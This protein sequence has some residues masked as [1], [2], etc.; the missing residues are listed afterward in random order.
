MNNKQC[1]NVL[2]SDVSSLICFP[3][4]WTSAVSIRI[5]QVLCLSCVC[6]YCFSSL[7][8]AY[9]SLAA[10]HAQLFKSSHEMPG[11]LL[12]PCVIW[13]SGHQWPGDLRGGWCSNVHK[14][15]PSST[16]PPCVASSAI[17]LSPGWFL[18]RS[19]RSMG[20]KEGNLSPAFCGRCKSETG[21]VREAIAKVIPATSH[22]KRPKFRKVLK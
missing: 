17:K 13:P 10:P 7:F 9:L 18:D 14:P 16:C 1:S 11:V 19:S 21:R 6:P 15:C 2:I 12:L 8:L 5:W 3:A 20:A 4:V 22:H